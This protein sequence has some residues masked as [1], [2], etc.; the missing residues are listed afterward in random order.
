MT[1]CAP[2]GSASEISPL[3]VPPGS[4]VWSRAPETMF[5]YIEDLLVPE[6]S[7]PYTFVVE[8]DAILFVDVNTYP[9]YETDEKAQVYVSLGC[10][11]LGTILMKARRTNV[12]PPGL[13]MYSIINDKMQ[14]NRYT[15]MGPKIPGNYTLEFDSDAILPPG[16][17]Y[18]GAL[19][20]TFGGGM[21]GS[22]NGHV[23]PSSA[24]CSIA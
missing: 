21:G 17:R 19:Q 6:A 9:E 15:D 5:G 11:R 22:W 7:I 24:R 3:S 14:F 4:P 16:F 13:A 23:P 12:T 10:G 18:E 2:T 1:W 8:T 20:I